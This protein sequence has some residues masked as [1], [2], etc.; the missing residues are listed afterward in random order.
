MATEILSCRLCAGSKLELVLDYGMMPPAGGFAPVGDPALKLLEPLTLVRCRRCSL[1]QTGQSID[2]NSIFRNYTYQSSISSELQSHF[3]NLA[4][5]LV[6]MW[7]VRGETVLDIGC[8]DG[9]LLKPL[10]MLGCKCV[11]IDPSDVAAIASAMHGFDLVNSYMT[12]ETASFIVSEYGKIKLITASNVL[13]HTDKIHVMMEGVRNCID[14]LHGL[15]IAEVHYQGALINKLQID[16]V[17][18]EHTCYYNLSSLNRLFSD[19]DMVIWD[20]EFTDIHAG[21]I[22]VYAC[23]RNRMQKVNP[24]V[25]E[26]IRKESIIDSSV[27]RFKLNASRFR[28]TIYKVLSDLKRQKIYAYGAAGRSTILLNWCN[29]D[30]S[31]VQLVVDDSP[32][33]A[34]RCV[35]G[36]ETPIVSPDV[37]IQDQ[38]GYCLITAWNYRKS[39]TQTHSPNYKGS[40][41]I[42]LPE[43]QIL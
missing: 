11:G 17:Y 16:T 21:S 15:F 34:G 26:L 19:H 31:I 38:P 14:Q 27:L 7:N 29:I 36:V 1:M 2:P 22:R 43:I 4:D 30:N 40:W 42:P 5:K 39:I 12:P 3:S 9:I 32:L 28:D 37:L 25:D 13:A 33:R 23:H 20:Y 10:D 8:N 41:I 18:H 6:R 24:R 35:P